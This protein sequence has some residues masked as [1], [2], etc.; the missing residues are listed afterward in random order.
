MY[1]FIENDARRRGEER[2]EEVVRVRMRVE[3]LET[4]K[5]DQFFTK[6]PVD[7]LM[8]IFVLSQLPPFLW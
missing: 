3:S 6:V 2:R 5:R 8:E 7:K 4:D 1:L